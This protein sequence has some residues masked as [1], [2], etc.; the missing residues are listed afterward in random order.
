MSVLL[1]CILSLFFIPLTAQQQRVNNAY[2]QQNQ[3]Y[4][5]YRGYK[6][7]ENNKYEE[8]VT[9]YTRAIQLDSGFSEAYRYRGIANCYLKNY[10][11]ALADFDSAIKL[12]PK[13]AAAYNSRGSVYEELNILQ[14]AI[15]D[16]AKAV[17]IA[18]HNKHYKE[19]LSDAQ[20]KAAAK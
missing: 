6:A 12:D 4:W 16:Y 1:A 14:V 7:V 19:N 3:Y 2:P 9:N 13:D 17:E 18:P 5:I 20:D 11:A 8:A 15:Q 10:N